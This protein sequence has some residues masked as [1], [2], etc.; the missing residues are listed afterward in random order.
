VQAEV[1]PLSEKFHD[2]AQQVCAK[3]AAAGFRAH[4]DDRNEKLQ[5]KIR[6]AQLA[7]I[8]YMLILGGKEQ[9]AQSVSVRHR[10]KG[11]Q[12][13]CPLDQFLADLCSEVESKTM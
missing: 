10:T 1:L 7:K 4:L 2:Y 8:P 13:P 6:D 5:A 11:D 12:G 3:L 9:E